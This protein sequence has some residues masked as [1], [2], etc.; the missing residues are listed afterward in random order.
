VVLGVDA[1]SVRVLRLLPMPRGPVAVAVDARDRRAIVWS[2]LARAVTLVALDGDPRRLTSTTLERTTTPPSAEVLR[3]RALFHATFDSRVSSDGRACASC[4]TD[5]RDDGLTWSSPGGPMQT[6][7]LSSRLPETAPYGWDGTARDLEQHLRHTTARLGGTGLSK[8]DVSDI[9][10]YLAS[11]PL[12]GGAPHDPAV[13][14]RGET[15]FRSEGAECSSCHSGVASTDG[16]TH[17]VTERSAARSTRGFDTPSLRAVA[18]SA[19]YF[20]DGRYATLE[21]LL[22]GSDGAMG[23][24]SQLEPQDRAALI[25]YLES[26]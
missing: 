5:G 18:R 7:M 1:P 6:P 11:L 2:P 17:V 26:L 16:D 13:L 15:V 3:G 8:Q 23:H 12:P 10:A 24:T 21:E 20:H 14:A 9:A 19:P 25:A 22:S 4:H